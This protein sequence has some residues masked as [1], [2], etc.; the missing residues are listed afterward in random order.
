NFPSTNGQ[1]NS[2]SLPQVASLQTSLP[3]PP[4]APAAAPAP[5]PVAPP[6]VMPAPA[7]APEFFAAA[8]VHLPAPPSRSVRAP[9]PRPRPVVRPPVDPVAQEPLP[10]QET[11]PPQP[12]P[13]HETWTMGP[14][15]ALAAP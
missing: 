1:E 10:W 9:L 8:P 12:E 4:P 13:A 2:V 15:A 14:M 11:F 5:L 7:P 3:T 6:P